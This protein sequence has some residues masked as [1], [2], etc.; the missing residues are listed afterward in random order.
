[1]SIDIQIVNLLSPFGKG[2][3]GNTTSTLSTLGVHLIIFNRPSV[4]A[5]LL[6]EQELRGIVVPHFTCSFAVS[7]KQ[8]LGGAPK[9]PAYWPSA[10]YFI[11]SRL[12]C[13]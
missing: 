2:I 3:S 6:Q 11:L 5:H 13:L 4:D 7:Y 12:K 1:M 8:L 10:P 9:P